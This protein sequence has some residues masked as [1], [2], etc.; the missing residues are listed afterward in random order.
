MFCR[1]VFGFSARAKIATPV[2][3][4][5]HIVQACSESSTFRVRLRHDVKQF[6][7]RDDVSRA[8]AGKK[9]TITK[10]K[11]KMQKRFITDHLQNLHCKFVSENPTVTISYALFC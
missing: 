9:E 11:R 8:T 7:L 5:K 3:N 4:R 1:D 2:S 10:N 6:Y